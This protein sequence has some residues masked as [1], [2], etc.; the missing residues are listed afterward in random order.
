MLLKVSTQVF[1]K[2]PQTHL[3][4]RSSANQR[5]NQILWIDGVGGFLLLDREE[6]LIGQAV[7]GGHQDIGVVGDLSR[8]AAVLQRVQSDYVVQPLQETCVDGRPIAGPHL[9]ATGETL[10]WGPR[11]RMKFTKPHP[12]SSSARLNLVSQH[13]FQPRVDGVILLADSCILGPSSTCHVHC[14]QWSQDLL[15]FR[16]SNQWFF[17]VMEELEVDGVSRTG[18]VA[19]TSGLRVRGSDFSFSVE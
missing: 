12:L 4:D 14:P 10:S 7:S 9:L 15:M 17:R 19:L 11:V 18:Q 13:R 16:S 6:L 8:Q 2:Q 5:R 3:S 1:G